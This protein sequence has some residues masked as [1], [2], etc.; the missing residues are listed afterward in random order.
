M[1]C[2]LTT[3]F[4]TTDS[5]FCMN[6]YYMQSIAIYIYEDFC[7]N[8]SHENCN[9]V[10]SDASLLHE[11][12][13]LIHCILHCV[14]KK[15]PPCNCLWICQILIDVQNFCTAEK[16]MKFATKLIQHYPPHLRNVATLA[17]EIKNSNCMQIFSRYGRKCKQI[18]FWVHR[19]SADCHMKRP[20]T[21]FCGGVLTTTPL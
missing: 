15:S 4:Y 11:L 19:S 21:S 10:R 14:S 7:E 20:R 6:F 3:T 8:C 16:R 2:I 5:Y 17:W 13:L 18:A 12:S 1:F 9:N